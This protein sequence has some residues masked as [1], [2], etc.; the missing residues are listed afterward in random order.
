MRA[1]TVWKIILLFAVAGLL[2]GPPKH[3]NSELVSGVR[4]ARWLPRNML[5]EFIISNRVSGGLHGNNY[6][7]LGGHAR[8]ASDLAWLRVTEVY[9]PT[10]P[11]L[12]IETRR[13]LGYAYGAVDRPA[14]G[15]ERMLEAARHPNEVGFYGASANIFSWEAAVSL[16]YD[17]YGLDAA[18]EIW[19]EGAAAIASNEEHYLAAGI[20]DGRVMMVEDVVFT[21]QPADWWSQE[22]DGFENGFAARPRTAL[23]E[24]LLDNGDVEAARQLVETMEIDGIR[25][26]P[27]TLANIRLALIDLENDRGHGS[28]DELASFTRPVLDNWA[29]LP[30]SDLH[31]GPSLTEVVRVLRLH[32]QLDQ[33]DRLRQTL[34]HLM[35]LSVEALETDIRPPIAHIELWRKTNRTCILAS[36]R[37]DD[38][39][40]PSCQRRDDL[41]QQDASGLL[42]REAWDVHRFPAV[43]ESPSQALNC[44]SS[45][46]LN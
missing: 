4:E 2:M 10:N 22:L 31:A 15:A 16:S 36:L 19:R 13:A 23:V 33:C 14:S 45:A 21:G 9:A 20:A 5:S 26:W 8:A 6:Q 42:Q 18:L 39:A 30:I 29:R 35:E 7:M 40:G 24:R 43:P 28:A 44:Y 41:W 17:A 32:D 38:E 11:G 12:Y 46:A 34:D 27:L 25:G 1:K 37:G 3:P